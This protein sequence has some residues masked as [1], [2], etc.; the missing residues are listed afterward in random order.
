[1]MDALYSCGAVWAV[2]VW[3]ASDA[4]FCEQV[5]SRV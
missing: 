5:L 1:M 4:V 3:D 2:A